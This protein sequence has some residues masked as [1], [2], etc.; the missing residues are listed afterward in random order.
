MHLGEVN[1]GGREGREVILDGRVSEQTAHHPPGALGLNTKRTS[2]SGLSACG[3]PLILNRILQGPHFQ[4]HGWSTD[5]ATV[6]C[7]CD[8]NPVN[9]FGK[10]TTNKV[11]IHE[12]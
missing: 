12:A 2:V 7:W 9:P 6:S 10:N 8:T 11:H 4:D 3:P 1:E 5:L